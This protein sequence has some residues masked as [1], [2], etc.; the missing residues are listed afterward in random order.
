MGNLAIARTKHAAELA[1]LRD[2]AR[3]VERNL[4][5]GAVSAGGFQRSEWET[6]ALLNQ[7][8]ELEGQIVELSELDDDSIMEKYTPDLPEE[9]REALANGVNFIHTLNRGAQ[10]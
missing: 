6:K 2:K 8:S 5:T 10:Y 1:I 9:L 4:E 7:L 3:S